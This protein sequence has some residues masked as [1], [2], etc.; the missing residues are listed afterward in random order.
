MDD[1]VKG[2]NSITDSIDESVTKVYAEYMGDIISKIP[3]AG[4]LKILVGTTN[5]QAS[6]YFKDP[7]NDKI[8]AS[9]YNNLL[10]AR[11]KGMG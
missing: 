3:S 6:F 4:D 2:S 8:N 7:T 1:I 9:L 10:S 5:A 11:I